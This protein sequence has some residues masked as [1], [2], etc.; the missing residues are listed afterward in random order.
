MV[1]RKGEAQPKVSTPQ[2]IVGLIILALIIGVPAYFIYNFFSREG[3]PTVPEFQRVE[4]EIMVSASEV[5]STS[6]FT[7]TGESSEEM[8]RYIDYHYGNNDG[9]LAEDEVNGFL[10]ALETKERQKIQTEYAFIDGGSGQIA[11]V[12]YYVISCPFGSIDTLG[13]FVFGLRETISWAL[14]EENEHTYSMAG[15]VS[16]DV[17]IFTA[18]LGWEI[19]SAGGLSSYSISS[20]KR[21][22]TGTAAGGNIFTT[23]AATGPKPAEFQV[24]NLSISPTQVEPGE[25]VIISVDVKNEGDVSGTYTVTLKIDGTTEA[26]KDIT[27]A[28]GE[29]GTVSFTVAKTTEQTYSVDIGRLTGGFIVKEPE[30]VYVT[31]FTAMTEY[32]YSLLDLMTEPW[33]RHP[34]EFITE[35]SAVYGITDEQVSD[36]FDIQGNKFKVEYHVDGDYESGIC[37]IFIYPEGE[38]IYYVSAYPIY[39][40]YVLAEGTYEVNEGP[41]TY[42]IAFST[43][44]I[45]YCTVDIYDWR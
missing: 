32:W 10:T 44:Y 21:T 27:L 18:P 34:D 38:Y 6:T 19:K 36:Y 24:S 8:R 29:I 17:V 2:L 26:T 3:A 4:N 13:D 1:P 42:C 40:P 25:P 33:N 11:E 45:E 9:N 35:A 39:T 28:G 16:G 14:E 20:D 5:Q 22:L 31:T 15:L 7:H 37:L 41:G 43:E 23:F 12:D 30:W